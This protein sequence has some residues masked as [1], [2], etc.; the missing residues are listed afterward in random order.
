MPIKGE[1]MNRRDWLVGAG[2]VALAK[3]AKAGPKDKAGEHRHDAAPYGPLIDAVMEC[4]KRSEA[5]LSHCI[6]MLSTGDTSMAAC[7]VTVRDTLALSNALTTLAAAGSKHTKA[8]AKLCA[9]VCRD[10]EAEC[11]KH[12]DKMQVCRDCADACAKMNQ[13]VAKL[14]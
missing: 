1:R 5:C 3:V 12:Q 11:R 14:T 13:E 6:S 9:E 2:A 10:C 4:Q 8:F 7:A